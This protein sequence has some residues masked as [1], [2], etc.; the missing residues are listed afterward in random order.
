MSKITRKLH[1]T[2]SPVARDL[3]PVYTAVNEDEARQRLPDHRFVVRRSLD[4]CELA[5]FHCF[6]P[7]RDPLGEVIRAIGSRWPV[8]ECFEA[9]KQEAGL[10]QYQ[11]RKYD[12]WYRHIT[13]AMLALCLLA[14][15][16][17][18]LQKGHLDLW[19]TGRPQQNQPA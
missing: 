1:G 18:T 16:R 4:R 2:L 7:R 11:V 12:A 8:E 13:V 6:T 17:Q 5:Y 14:V 19:T 10:D 3:K 9:A 15:M